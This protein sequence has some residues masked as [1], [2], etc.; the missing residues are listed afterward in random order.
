LEDLG[1]QTF[2]VRMDFD[3]ELRARLLNLPAPPLL[4]VFAAAQ[5]FEWD[6]RAA[7]FTRDM[8]ATR[9]RRLLELADLAERFVFCRQAS[10]N[11]W[12][13]RLFGAARNGW[14][15]TSA[16]LEQARLTLATWQA[17]CQRHGW[18]ALSAKCD[19]ATRVRLQGTVLQSTDLLFAA[20]L[21]WLVARPADFSGPGLALALG[22]FLASAL[23]CPL[24]RSAYARWRRT[25]LSGAW[26]RLDRL[27][28]GLVLFGGVAVVGMALAGASELGTRRGWDWLF[29]VV[30]GPLVA[31]AGVWFA[32]V[33]WRGLRLVEL[34]VL[35][36]LRAAQSALADEALA[37]LRRDGPVRWTRPGALAQ[38]RI[39]PLAWSK[40]RAQRRA[41]P[42]ANRR[43]QARSA[44]R[45]YWWIWFLIVLVLQLARCA[46][47]A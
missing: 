21:A 16:D 9:S 42:I 25:R 36:P 44:R 12:E 24:G 19:P 27:G 28:R 22:G 3:A 38:F 46:Q 8:G 45:N 41:S 20:T 35:T 18:E 33:I 39:L 4:L 31:L 7:E 32:A 10:R 2:D 40:W 1:A 6:N 5:A 34:L 11:L 26:A 14:F 17:R 47:G 29:W 30:L 15:G 13:R 23:L 43:A 37:G